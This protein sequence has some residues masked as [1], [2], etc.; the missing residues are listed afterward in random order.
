MNGTAAQDA[1]LSPIMDHIISR[2]AATLYPFSTAIN[3]RATSVQARTLYAEL[4]SSII[5]EV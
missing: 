5:G 1:H 2:G 4:Q 3:L